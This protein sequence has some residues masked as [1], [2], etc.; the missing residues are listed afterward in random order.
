MRQ[1]SAPRSTTASDLSGVFRPAGA[2]LTARD[3]RLQPHQNCSGFA[4]CVGLH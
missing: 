2:H 4:I 1:L 3:N